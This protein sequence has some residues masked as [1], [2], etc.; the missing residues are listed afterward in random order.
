MK[1]YLENASGP[2]SHSPLPSDTP[3]AIMLG[4]STHITI[5]LGPIF[6]TLKTSSGVGRSSTASG[7]RLTP[8]CRLVACPCGEFVMSVS[9]S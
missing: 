8:I 7:G 3:S 9:S 6:E 4:P 2:S 5:S 1:P